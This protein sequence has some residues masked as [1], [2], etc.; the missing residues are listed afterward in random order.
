MVKAESI[1]NLDPKTVLCAAIVANKSEKLQNDLRGK[2]YKI[3][4]DG[5]KGFYA[6]S[7]DILLYFAYGQEKH[8]AKQPD[9]EKEELPKAA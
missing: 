4:T 5:N 3:E 7:G 6:R 9:Q 1:Q 8:E 2:N